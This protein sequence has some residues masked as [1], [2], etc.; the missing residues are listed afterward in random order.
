VDE[1]MSRDY[2]TRPPFM[3]QGLDIEERVTDLLKRLTLQEKLSLCSGK[4]LWSTK[5]V[6]RLGIRGF[7]MTDG[8]NGL[9]AILSVFK[10]GTYFP[11]SICRTATWNPDLSRQFGTALAQEARSIGYQM[12][13]APAVNIDRTPLGGRTFEYQT[14]DPYLNRK[15][16]VAVVQGIQS[17]R[18]A[19]CVKHFACNNQETNRTKVSSQVSERSLR[20]IYLQA[21]EAVVREADAWSVMAAYNKVNGIYCCESHDLLTK[22]LREEWGFRGFVV[23]DWYAAN[24]TT[25]TESCVNAGLSLEMPGGGSRYS[26]KALRTA[27]EAGKFS[28]DALDKNLTGLLRVMF[29][30]GLFNDEK[31]LPAGSRNTPEHQALARR[32]AE[33][34]I[35]LLKNEGDILPLKIEEVKRIAVLGPNADKK[36]G[37]KGGSSMVRPPYE[38]TPLNGLRERCGEKTEIVRSP[39]E[40]DVAIVFA[41]LSQGLLK[42]IDTEGEDKKRLE[43]TSDQVALINSTVDANPRTVVVLINGSPV[44]MDG[45]LEKVPTVLEAWYAGQ[46]AGHAIAG[47]LFGDVNPSGKLP[48]TF[49]RRLSDCPAHA[50]E[51]TFPGGEEVYYDE[52]VFVGYRHFDTRGI[53]PLFPFG[54]GLSYTK[55]SYENLKIDGMKV[56]ADVTNAGEVAGAEVVQLYVHDS[57]SSVERPLKELKGFEKVHL[58]PGRTET[59]TFTLTEEDL[60]F[61][62]EKTGYWATEAGEFDILVGSSSRDTRLQG[63]LEYAE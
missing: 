30:V 61:W 50:S 2:L 58:D 41:G 13:L 36:M 54:H 1:E 4:N 35:V 56:S 28:E 5:P 62:D 22:R 25:S 46:E 23:S 37:L 7:R 39:A 8:P 55:F 10:K 57:T 6:E 49:P 17:Q 18:I 20:E 24:P 51:R 42:G 31:T 32:I 33:E 19:A 47:V 27:F 45:W 52:G 3:N 48:L 11:S 59:V 53:E 38:V 21:F 12:V 26:E 63:E 44:T 16:A 40:A 15:M 43:L 29:F 9:G 60:S 34:G 14:E